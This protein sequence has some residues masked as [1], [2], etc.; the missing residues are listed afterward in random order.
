MKVFESGRPAW[1]VYQESNSD[2]YDYEFHSAFWSR[3]MARDLAKELVID[4][5]RL[6]TVVKKVNIIIEGK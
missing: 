4:G 1:A 2:T 3:R 6:R 5:R